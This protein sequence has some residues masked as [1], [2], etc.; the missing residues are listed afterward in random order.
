MSVAGERVAAA[1]QPQLLGD[2]GDV[3]RP[4]GEE[5]P[6]RPD[7]KLLRVGFEH[8]GRISL[9]IDADRVEEEVFANPVAEKPLH[10]DQPRRL[11]RALPLATGVDEVDRHL[12]ALEQVVVEMHD[13]AVLRD[14]RDVRKIAGTPGAAGHRRA[15]R[16]QG[17]GTDE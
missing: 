4:A 3:V 17:R 12:L 16:Q 11:E 14:Q 5:Q 15:D 10:L 13:G 9:G 2:E 7:V 6:A 8:R 1:R